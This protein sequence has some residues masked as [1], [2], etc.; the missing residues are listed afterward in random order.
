MDV[1]LKII[2]KDFNRRSSHGHYGSTRREL[3]A[4]RTL[5]WIARIPL[6]H[7]HQHSYNHVVW[8]SASS[9]IA[10]VG[11]EFVFGRYLREGAFDFALVVDFVITV[12]SSSV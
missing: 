9:A 4:R 3:T 11:I 7:V 8:G 2:M 10:E 12:S 6:T 1:I 5:T